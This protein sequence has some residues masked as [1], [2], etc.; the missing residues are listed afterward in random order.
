MDFNKCFFACLG[1]LLS[2]STSAQNL[3]F[4]RV[5]DTILVVQTGPD[6]VDISLKFIGETLTPDAGKVFKVN[7]IMLQPLDIPYWPD[8]GEPNAFVCNDPGNTISTV[9]AGVD[10]FDGAKEFVL[11]EQSANVAT[12]LNANDQASG[13]IKQFPL[14]VDESST[15]RLFVWQGGYVPDNYEYPHCLRNYMAKAYVSLIEFHTEPQ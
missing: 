9:K 11:F 14:W 1:L 10:V 12:I 4:S 3:A 6:P 2:V 7:N 13:A 15:L 8:N 5:I